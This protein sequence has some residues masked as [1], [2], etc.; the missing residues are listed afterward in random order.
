V[1][2]PSKVLKVSGCVLDEVT[3]VLVLPKF[4][5]KA[6]KVNVKLDDL[7]PAVISQLR[8]YATIIASKYQDNPFHNFEHASHVTMSASKLL[9]CIVVPKNVNYQRD[10]KKAITSDL[11]DYTYGIT[12]D[13]LTQ[14]AAI[15]CALIH[16]VDHRGVSNL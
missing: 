1:T 4:D 9:S 10:N 5:E 2:E 14:F 3:E 6:T 11:H 15:F 12:S 8:D 16:D 7:S 13:P